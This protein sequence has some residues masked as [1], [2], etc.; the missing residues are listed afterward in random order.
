[1]FE[2]IDMG[3][4]QLRFLQGKDDT[5]SNLDIF[6]MTLQPNGRMPVP[7]YHESW[8]ETVYGLEGT[9]V[10]R[11]DGKD[12]ALTPGNTVFIKRGIVHGFF[13]QSG[14]AAKCLCILDPGALGTGYFRE[15]AALLANGAPDLAKMKAVML[16]YGLVPA[17]PNA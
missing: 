12:I 5:G 11:V 17:P 1:M 9:S 10:W 14:E 16:R 15:I 13:N 8:D 4:I 2:H 3:S 6:E 7:H